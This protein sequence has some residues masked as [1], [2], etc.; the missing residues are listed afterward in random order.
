MSARVVT[1]VVVTG[2]PQV[3]WM[4]FGM[5]RVFAEPQHELV[6]ANGVPGRSLLGL[7]I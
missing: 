2:P 1:D 7:R 5:L 4:V 3:S 6:A